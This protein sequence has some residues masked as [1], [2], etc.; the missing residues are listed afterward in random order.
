M[1]ESTGTAFANLITIGACKTAWPCVA[2]WATAP[3]PFYELKVCSLD[4]WAGPA[5][6]LTLTSSL[7]WDLVR[8]RFTEVCYLF[9]VENFKYAHDR[10]WVTM[11]ENM[12]G[13]W[14][15]LSISLA[16]TE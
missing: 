14:S 5:S 15:L 11:I 12:Y 4:L 2:H 9:C 3:P 16:M 1:N 10:L 8:V 13:S 6:S 7:Q